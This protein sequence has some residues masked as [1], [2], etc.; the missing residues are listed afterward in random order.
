MAFSA[1]LATGVAD[2]LGHHDQIDIFCRHPRPG[3]RLFV[4]AR[5]VV[6]H[7]TVYPG[8]IRE[9]KVLVLPAVPCVT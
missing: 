9:I 5:G 7:E 4:R 1:G 3:G 8:F 2:I 6:T